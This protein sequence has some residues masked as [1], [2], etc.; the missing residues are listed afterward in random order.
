MQPKLSWQTTLCASADESGASIGMVTS[1][2]DGF[3]L[4]YIRCK[5]RGQ[6]VALEGKQV[7]SASCVVAFS[8]RVR[9][10]GCC[11]W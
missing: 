1:V 9:T 6:Q 2:T 5:S 11:I 10:E 7:G 4:G 3:A 8:S